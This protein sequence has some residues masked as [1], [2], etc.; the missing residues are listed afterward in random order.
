MTCP[1]FNDCPMQ[2]QWKILG[3][4]TL[5]ASV[6]YQSLYYSWKLTTTMLCYSFHTTRFVYALARLSILLTCKWHCLFMSTPWLQSII[7][8]SLGFLD[9]TWLQPFATR[10]ERLHHFQFSPTWFFISENCHQSMTSS[11]NLLFH[12]DQNL[13]CN[14]WTDK[15]LSNMQ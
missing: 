15:H 5:I 8:I 7:L 6:C 13:V 2:L 4:F 12:V 10:E 3:N 14:K 1:D 9:G 11:L